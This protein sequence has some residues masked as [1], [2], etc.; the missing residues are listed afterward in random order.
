MTAAPSIWSNR[1]MKLLIR[2]FQVCVVI[3]S[4]PWTLLSNSKRI[5]L[6][7]RALLRACRLSITLEG[8]GC[9]SNAT[10]PFQLA[11]CFP[12][13]QLR[14]LEE[15]LK[16]LTTPYIIQSL[17]AAALFYPL[18]RSK[19]WIRNVRL[20]AY[21]SLLFFLIIMQSL[22]GTGTT[23]ASLYSPGAEF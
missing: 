6:P 13:S 7:N 16:W 3:W 14:I 8:K 11:S 22:S 21:L 4:R 18:P 19:R 9:V 23:L 12:R 5:F 20:G 1:S 2:G 15:E 17:K 10:L